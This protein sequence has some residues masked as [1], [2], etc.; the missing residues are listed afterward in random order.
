QLTGRVQ[1]DHRL[2]WMAENTAASIPTTGLINPNYADALALPLKAGG[3]PLAALHLYKASGFFSDKDRQFVEAVAHFAAQV[4]S[5]L[6]A[7]R[8][9]EAE[10]ARLRGHQTGGGG[11]P[12]GSPVLGALR[13]P[14]GRGGAPRP[15]VR[16]VRGP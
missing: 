1:R 13:G 11:V 8:V 6:K 9:L 10:T 16:V 14:L 7:R 4:M 2:V 12:G 5:G 15:A 3:K